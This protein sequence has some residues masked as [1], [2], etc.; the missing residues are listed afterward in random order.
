MLRFFDST[1]FVKSR[2]WSG[3]RT[4]TGKPPRSS[5]SPPG[6]KLSFATARI[7]AL[8]ALSKI[9]H[10]SKH[11]KIRVVSLPAGLA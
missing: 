4:A 7:A 10:R 5:K 9:W 2:P 3:K 11:D 1:G 8:E 6:R